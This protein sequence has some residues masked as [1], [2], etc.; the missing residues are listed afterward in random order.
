VPHINFTEVTFKNFLSFGNT[1][2]TIQLNRSPTT[3]V[4]GVSGSGKSTILEA[5]TFCLYGV[6]FRNISKKDM[7]NTVN[8]KD[9]ETKVSFKIGTTDYV[10]VRGLKPSVFEI[11]IDGVLVDQSAHV[12]DYQSYLEETILN[13]SYKT[14]VQVVV[15]GYANYSP[16]LWLKASD[17]RLFVDEILGTGIFQKML[18]KS[19]ELQS[20]IK[21]NIT[22]TEST[23]VGLKTSIKGLKDNLITLQSQD[24]S[25]VQLIKDQVESEKIRIAEINSDLT[26]L[27]STAMTIASS[28]VNKSHI[29]EELDNLRAALQKLS[30]RSNFLKTDIGFFNSNT[31]CP[32]CAQSIDTD[33]ASKLIEVREAELSSI[34]KQTSILNSNI[35]DM[36]GSLKELELIESNLST[37]KQQA[38]SLKLSLDVHTKS[39]QSKEHDLRTVSTQGTEMV[40]DI[41]QRIVSLH[42]EVSALVEHKAA[43]GE[44]NR[45]IQVAQ[46]FL[47]EDGIKST[48]IKS[49]IPLLNDTINRYLDTMGFHMRFS[50]NEE[51]EE[52]ILARFRDSMSFGSL[53]QG[54]QSRI[55]L[56]ITLAWRKVAMSRNAVSTNLIFFDEVIDSALSASDVESVM[57]LM[58]EVGEESN[59]WIISHKPDLIS[60]YCRSVITIEKQGNFSRIV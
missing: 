6:P 13:I 32:A 36:L 54:E 29:T 21:N 57:S 50:L 37:L 4:Q 25:R 28:M 34:D 11:Y 3:L 43:L 35:E 40:K 38:V 45:Y 15:L 56:A 51:F 47:K 58:K 33:H 30:N 27:A 17:R 9:C 20:E 2:T 10:V 52:T 23:I 24:E 26:E 12:R 7:T 53:S 31:S 18:V 1:P 44:E 5:V 39:L 22:T 46:Q 48:I 42:D 14:W 41:A 19:R 8:L 60:S 49:Y 59:V 16:F 55:G